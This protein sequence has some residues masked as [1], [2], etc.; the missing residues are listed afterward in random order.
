MEANT[1]R[2]RIFQEAFTTA[3]AAADRVTFSAVHRREQLAESERL[4]TEEITTA[5]AAR[6]L[7]AETCEQVDDIC[8]L[9][10]REARPGDVVVLMSNG[11]F[12]GLSAKLVAALDLTPPTP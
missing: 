10:V 2:R 12:G 11:G 6:G 8:A 7:A 3:F 5:L 9:V 1:T 4:S